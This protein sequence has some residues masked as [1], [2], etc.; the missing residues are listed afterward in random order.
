MDSGRAMTRSPSEGK[1]IFVAYS[2]GLY[3]GPDFRQVFERVARRTGSE[4]VF[5]DTRFTSEHILDKITRMIHE[6]DFSLFDISDWN[7]N[8][9]LELGVA[10]ESGKPWYILIDPSKST[11]AI[12]EAPSDLRGFDRV[13]YGSFDELERGLVRLLTQKPH[14]ASKSAPRTLR[15][16]YITLFNETVDVESTNHETISVDVPQGARVSILARELWGQPFDPYIFNRRNYA[17]FCRDREG[18]ELYG[19]TDESV[20]EFERKIPRAG[21]WYVVLD[22]YNKRN[23]RRVALDVKYLPPDSA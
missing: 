20:I 3:Q 12:H 17:S 13:Q 2:Y 15:S 11:G 23:N 1:Q 7:P 5:A 18:R 6:A 9:T 16:D 10:K 21:E 14:S 19:V 8:V 22:A 4:F